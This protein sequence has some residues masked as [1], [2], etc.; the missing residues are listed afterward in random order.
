MKLHTLKLENVRQHADTELTLPSAG[1][2]GIVG[3]NETGKS[4]LLEAVSWALFGSKALRGTKGSLRWNRA[5]ARHVARVALEFEVGGK[6]YRVERSEADAKLSELVGG[7][8]TPIAESTSGVDE[9]VP[10]LV[11]MDLKEYEATYLCVQRD[12]GRFAAMGP[13]DRQKFVRGVMGLDRI[14]AALEAV[15]ARKNEL[16]RE[17]AWLEAGIGERQ[18]LRDEIEAAEE[19]A[20]FLREQFQDLEAATAELEGEHEEVAGRLEALDVT[21]ERHERLQREIEAATS[22][23]GRLKET[24]EQLE[25][26]AEERRHAE[27]RIRDAAPKVE[28]LPELRERRDALARAADRGAQRAQLEGTIG[29][30][31]EDVTRLTEE[32]AELEEAAAAHDEEQL[33]ATAEQFAEAEGLLEELR[34]ARRE[35]QAE[36][37]AQKETARAGAREA[38]EQIAALEEAGAGGECPTCTQ[39]LDRHHLDATLASLAERAEHFDGIVKAAAARQ[40]TAM[41]PTDQERRLASEIEELRKRGERLKEVRTRAREAERRAGNVRTQIQQKQDELG[42][43]RDQLE[44]MEVVEYSDEAFAEVKGLIADLEDLDRKLAAD[45][46]TVERLDGVEGR[47][48][49]VDEDLTAAR[50]HRAKQME[51]ALDPHYDAE[52]HEEVRGREREAR[53]RL[54]QARVDLAAARER[55]KAA[56]EEVGRARKRLVAYDERADQLQDAREA[57]RVHTAAAERLDAFR[58]EQASLIRPELEELTS[59]FISILTDGRHDSVT[60][61]EDFGVILQEAGLDTEVVSGGTEDLS[62]I[63]LRLAMSQMIAER[64][65]HPLSLLVLDEP[66]GSLDEVRRGNVLNLIRRLSGV[67]EQV[68]VISHVAETKDAVDHVIELAYDEPEGRSRVVSAPRTASVATEGPCA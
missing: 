4:T 59:G 9:Y 31:E 57:L 28:R 60:V 64:A 52:R 62:A 26:D 56:R 27:V 67:F 1:I 7:A 43:R 49:A 38:R 23:I 35:V 41:D 48:R 33:Q 12:L 30:L 55:G 2:T 53:K 54:E 50:A 16:G 44:A 3:A 34:A 45:R 14:D 68:L 17:L 61:T 47:I 24:R 66:F 11:G 8:A 40:R 58:V 20:R 65:G 51:A 39:P 13:T 25:R 10:G 21:K 36:A 22:E 46:A 6:R 37:L 63:A 32:L 19:K 29:R 15:R 5:P 42:R 18:P